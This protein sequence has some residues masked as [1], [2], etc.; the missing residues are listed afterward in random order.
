MINFC[1]PSSDNNINAL[2]FSLQKEI[3]AD[4]ISVFQAIK[5]GRKTALLPVCATNDSTEIFI[6]EEGDDFL[7][8]DENQKSLLLASIF[9]AESFIINKENHET[10][11]NFCLI[12][13]A[14]ECSSKCKILTSCPFSGS[15]HLHKMIFPIVLGGFQLGVVFCGR[16][17]KAFSHKELFEAKNASLGLYHYFLMHSKKKILIDFFPVK[18]LEL[19]NS[20]KKNL[21]IFSNVALTEA[22]LIAQRMSS[23]YAALDMLSLDKEEDYNDTTLYFKERKNFYFIINEKNDRINE[24]LEIIKRELD[25]LKEYGI[26]ELQAISQ[27][28]QKE[29]G[30]SISKEQMEIHDEFCKHVAPALPEE[31]SFKI[32]KIVLSN[33][34]V[35]KFRHQ[36]INHFT[37]ISLFGLHDNL[38]DEIKEGIGLISKDEIKESLLSS[39]RRLESFKE[40]IHCIAKMDEDYSNFKKIF[41]TTDYFKDFF[42]RMEKNIKNFIYLDQQ[43]TIDFCYSIKSSQKFYFSPEAIE[44]ILKVLITNACEEL[45]EKHIRE[46][47]SEANILRVEMTVENKQLLIT[48]ED[49][50]RGVSES[51]RAK[52]FEFYSTF[53]KPGG[54]GMGLA[55]VNKITRA[56]GGKIEYLPLE[57]GSCF[58]ATLPIR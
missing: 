31:Q 39:M 38:K 24:S 15:Q 5:E 2:V 46:N 57:Y 11:Y 49:S 19:K 3:N 42:I 4:K 50:G 1:I 23:V 53:G 27:D 28:I 55:L 14:K 25:K 7:L 43:I 34:N 47:D 32:K 6:R 26:L 45:G 51:I 13:S 29:Y 52:L 20:R 21:N 37:L 35:R 16:Y 36:I 56:F 12:D 22:F 48:V 30:F 17:D 54:T 40:S 8:F 18:P 44:D 10:M 41:S 33:E 58:V 9:Y